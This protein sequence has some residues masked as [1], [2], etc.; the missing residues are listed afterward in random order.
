VVEQESESAYLAEQF[1][2][3]G[4]VALVTG[5][6]QGIGRAVAAGLARAGAHVA[7][8]SRD[9]DSMTE[10]CAEL[11]ALGGEPLPL[12]LDVND[13]E[14]IHAAVDSVR[15]RWGRLDIL[16]NNAGVSIRKEAIAYTPEEWDTVVD[17]NLRGPFLVSQAAARAMWTDGGRI[18]NLSSTFGRAAVSH[19]APYA[20]SKAGLEHLTRVLAVEWAPRGIRVNAVAPGTIVTESRAGLFSDEEAV[21][22]RIA[23]FPLGRLGTVEDVV[24]AVLLLAGDAGEFITGQTIVVDGGFTLG[25]GTVP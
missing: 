10:V 11:A 25:A 5:A 22:R 13:S 23:Q 17:T 18:V 1:G 7:V 4:C 15:E 16:V 6:R 12:S 24:G 3:S 20:A 2:V 21:R 9:G 8:T 19:R 14:Q